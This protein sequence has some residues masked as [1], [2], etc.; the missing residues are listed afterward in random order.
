MKTENLIVTTV[1]VEPLNYATQSYDYG[2]SAK[3]QRLER[4][5]LVHD[6]QLIPQ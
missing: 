1:K 5:L 2:G 6:L 4:Y 3:K